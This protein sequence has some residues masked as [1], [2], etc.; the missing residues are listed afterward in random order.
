MP[1]DKNL[2]EDKLLEELQ[3]KDR[4]YSRLGFIFLL[5]VIALSAIIEFLMFSSLEYVAN[6][7]LSEMSKALD[8]ISKRYIAISPDLKLI[9]KANI[10]SSTK[11]NQIVQAFVE[12]ECNFGEANI[13]NIYAPYPSFKTFLDKSPLL[14]KWKKH[15][16]TKEAYLKFI[17]LARFLYAQ[18]RLSKLPEFFFPKN[19]STQSFLFKK[20]NTF[21][22]QG[23]VEYTTVYLSMLDGKWKVGNTKMSVYLKG[24]IDFSVADPVNNPYGMKVF[25]FTFQI[26]LKPGG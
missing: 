20:D 18:G 7:K 11:A 17:N 15:F 26:P 3:K 6:S 23:Y 10:L 1:N 19:V 25:D 9:V 24:K 14:S 8:T 22:W 21:E 16:I 4:F 2:K 5:S 12:K 13:W